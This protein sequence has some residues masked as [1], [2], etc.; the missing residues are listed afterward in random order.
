VPTFAYRAVTVE[1]RRTRGVVSASSEAAAARDLEARGL[2]PLDLREDE[3]GFRP[4]GGGG[5]TRRAVLEFTRGMAALLPAGMPLSRALGASAAT[6]PQSIHA[7]LAEV[8]ERVQRGE[9]LGSALAAHPDVFSPLYVG[10]VRAGEKSGALDPA[11]VRLAEHLERED[12]LR[13]KLVSMAI[14]PAVLAAVGLASVLVLVL[15]VLPRFAEVLE[16]SGA[17]L[18]RSTAA[19]LAVATAAR[20]GW[21][22]LAFL[23]VGA[24][25]TL[26]WMRGTE[27]GRRVASR[28]L[29]SVPVIG[30]WRRQ[31]LAA[32]FAR[33]CGELLEG[34]SPVLASLR[35]AGDCMGDP[36]AK[37]AVERIRTGVR[38]GS[39]FHRAVAGEEIF[40]PELWQLVALGEEAG[41]LSEFL[42]K[43]ADLL[44]RRTERALERM[45]AL[46]EPAVIV[47]FG[48]VVAVVALSLLQAIYG[49]NPGAIP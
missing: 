34:G 47:A 37:E 48:G 29:L 28:L 23:P 2:L 36:L 40:P 7:P 44:E 10:I 18:P 30:A 38:E 27:A 24:F 41:R 42:L 20:E 9:E 13:S 46:T 1:G 22:V 33:M 45:V 16:G 19:V 26:S 31:A 35:D 5:G 14:Y 21:L 32:R 17:P 4:T 25:L 11:F 43:A 3:D 12:Q 49:V 39:P 15:F 8:R 6:S